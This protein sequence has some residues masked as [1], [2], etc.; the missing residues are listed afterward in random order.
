MAFRGQCRNFKNRGRSAEFIPGDSRM[1][2]RGARPSE[3][4]N[5]FRAPNRYLAAGSTRL[6]FG[7]STMKTETELTSKEC[8][9]CSSKTP[10]LDSAAIQRLREELG[11]GWNVVK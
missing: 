5:E 10:R 8:V 9:P 3:S 7:D 2:T 6:R 4:R 11:E 1:G